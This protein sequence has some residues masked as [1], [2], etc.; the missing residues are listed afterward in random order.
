MFRVSDVVVLKSG[1]PPMT[2]KEADGNEVNCEWFLK[3][4]TIQQ[5]IFL[6]SSLELFPSTSSA[7]GSLG[8]VRK[9]R[10]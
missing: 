1:G 6:I 3:D 9:G 2:V 10:V 5:R 4:H 7:S 8:E